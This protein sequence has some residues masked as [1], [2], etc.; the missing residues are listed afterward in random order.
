MRQK[1]VC[2]RAQSRVIDNKS[3]GARIMPVLRSLHY[4][5]KD[6]GEFRESR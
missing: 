1:T 6:S 4:P 3:L 2:D 5:G